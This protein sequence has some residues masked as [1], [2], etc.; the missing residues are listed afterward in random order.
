M[1]SAT[2]QLPFMDSSCD[3]AS[4]AG[5]G[6][7]S[8]VWNRFLRLWLEEN[9]LLP[10]LPRQR[11]KRW[12]SLLD[13]VWLS[14]HLDHTLHSTANTRKKCPGSVYAA[15]LAHS[16][17]SSTDDLT[18]LLTPLVLFIVL[19]TGF[20]IYVCEVIYCLDLS[21]EK[22][23]NNISIFVCVICAKWRH[24]YSLKSIYQCCPF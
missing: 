9:I 2:A 24:P 11:S 13:G 3:L 23:E 12:W 20:F 22:I 21:D 18:G 8:L 7:E 1:L 14:C 17:Q 10:P 6:P 5:P 19:F 15:D 4:L 16:K